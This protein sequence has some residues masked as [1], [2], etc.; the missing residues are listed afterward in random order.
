MAKW[1]LG[2]LVLLLVVDY[3]VYGGHYSAIADDLF[4]EMIHGYRH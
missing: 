2:A 4:K 3:V 1:I